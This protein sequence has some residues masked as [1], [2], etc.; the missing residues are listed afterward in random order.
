M[1]LRVL[2]LLLLLL[3]MCPVLAQGSYENC[4][5][6]YGS[7]PKA[8]FKKKVVS[9]RIQESDGGCNI[10]AVIFTLELKKSRILCAD[11][12]QPWVKIL[13]RYA[14]WQS[15]RTKSKN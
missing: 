7:E 15:K 5:L 6:K 8:R 4:C 9:Y 1:Q 11:P 13:T 3:C 10:P 2:A 14:D 12:K